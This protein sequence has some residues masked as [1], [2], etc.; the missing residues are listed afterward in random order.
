[1]ITVR[2]MSRMTGNINDMEFDMTAKEYNE[3]IKKY[4]AGALVQ[5]VFPDCTAD[6]REFI[7]TGMTPQEWADLFPDEE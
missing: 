6:Q 7:V 1:M 3:R 2:K 5:D 4:N